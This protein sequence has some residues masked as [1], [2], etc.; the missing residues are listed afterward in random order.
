LQGAGSISYVIAIEKADNYYL[1]YQQ[2]T[3]SEAE[4]NY[5]DS[6]KIIIVRQY[7]DITLRM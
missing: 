4:N 1:K 5:L 7:N 3:S 6:L 2:K